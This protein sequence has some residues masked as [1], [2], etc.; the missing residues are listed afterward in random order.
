MFT[1]N[2]LS[3]MQAENEW[4][5]DYLSVWCLF[6]RQRT[7]ECQVLT[8]CESIKKAII[9]HLQWNLSGIIQGYS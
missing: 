8:I 7:G 2:I 1:G 6:W 9:D 3:P 5:E 4:H